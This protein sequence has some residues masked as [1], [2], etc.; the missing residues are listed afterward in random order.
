MSIVVI[1][2]LLIA[3]SDLETSEEHEYERYLE[4]CQDVTSYE[5]ALTH[6][7]G[8]GKTDTVTW[9][10]LQKDRIDAIIAY[11]K[12]TRKHEPA[13]FKKHSI[14]YKIEPGWF[15]GNNTFCSIYRE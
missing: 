3:I 14:P 4:A 5:A 8:D 11:N 10:G 12:M 1:C 9:E 15:G 13:W 6:L 2:C 7:F